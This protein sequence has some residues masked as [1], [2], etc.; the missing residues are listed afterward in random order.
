MRS[1]KHITDSDFPLANK[2]DRYN[3]KVHQHL[4]KLRTLLAGLAVRSTVQPKV[5]VIHTIPTAENRSSWERNWIG[6]DAF[7]TEGKASQLGRSSEGEV[8]W[9]RQ[10]F[11]W[12]L[13]ILFSSGTTG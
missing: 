2:N 12:P 9:S 6:W 3:A 8:E 13:W 11:D 4:P 1:C 10:S 5:V 7:V